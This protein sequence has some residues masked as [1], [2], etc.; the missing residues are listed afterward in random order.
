MPRYSFCEGRHSSPWQ[1]LH[2]L[3]LVLSIAIQANTVAPRTSVAASAALLVRADLT[4]QFCFIVLVVVRGCY[5]Y[6]KR[7]ER[8][9]KYDSYNFRIEKRGDV[10]RISAVLAVLYCGL[11]SVQ[12][13]PHCNGE[14][15]KD[16]ANKQ[17][18]PPLGVQCSWRE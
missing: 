3:P 7:A 14:V 6:A 17:D 18:V 2:P 1:V 15:M 8:W 11:Q 9:Q 12:I 13:L 5:P 4:I 16:F 10:P